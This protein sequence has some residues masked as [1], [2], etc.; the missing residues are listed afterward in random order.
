MKIYLSEETN[1]QLLP[2]REWE[3]TIVRVGR[4]GSD[5]QI[6]FDGNQWPMVSRKHAEFRIEGGRRV[7]VDLNSRFGTFLDGRQISEPAEIRAGSRVQF[8][9]AGPVLRVVR[10]SPVQAVG[11]SASGRGRSA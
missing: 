1:G 10:I 2:E 4:D 8:G 11:N 5:C 9:Q 6:V 7:L 3:L